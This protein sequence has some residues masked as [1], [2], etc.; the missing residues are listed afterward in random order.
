[1]EGRVER[2]RTVLCILRASSC[3]RLEGTWRRHPHRDCEGVTKDKKRI[4]RQTCQ[5]IQ[6]KSQPQERV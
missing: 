4:R 3:G 2:V 1:M 5:G 6:A